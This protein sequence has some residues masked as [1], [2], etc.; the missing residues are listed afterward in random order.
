MMR[1]K[2]MRKEM[3]KMV[4]AIEWDFLEENMTGSWR[5]FL[6]CGLLQGAGCKDVANKSQMPKTVMTLNGSC[7]TVPCNLMTECQPIKRKNKKNGLHC[8]GTVLSTFRGNLT[9]YNCTTTLNNI[10]TDNDSFNF[11]LKCSNSK[12]LVFHKAVTIQIKGKCNVCLFETTMYHKSYWSNCG[13]NDAD[14]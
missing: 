7:V 12:P 5:L 13:S 6:L 11:I 1:L 14:H 4:K 3:M 8:T 10:Q 2:G 9:A